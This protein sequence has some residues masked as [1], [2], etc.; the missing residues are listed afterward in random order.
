M[1]GYTPLHQ[2]SEL[3]SSKS[4]VGKTEAGSMP[5]SLKPDAP[6][7][8][9]TLP[10]EA[11]PLPSLA[12]APQQQSSNVELVAQMLPAAT[13]EAVP[14][15]QT[16]LAQSAPLQIGQPSLQQMPSSMETNTSSLLT[17]YTLPSGGHA[18]Q[19]A[20]VLF[21]GDLDGLTPP[22][23]YLPS[24]N[25]TLVPLHINFQPLVSLQVLPDLTTSSPGQVG[26]LR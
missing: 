25:G 3:P 14:P 18:N 23:Y 20:Y 15:S 7:T 26:H 9:M 17:M 4:V 1:K 24:D 8:A 12:E 11:T 13:S 10:A 22:V 5:L 21:D 6:P 19:K 16:G 2:A